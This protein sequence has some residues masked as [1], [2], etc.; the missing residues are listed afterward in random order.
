MI[1]I[2][3]IYSHQ[4]PLGTGEYGFQLKL[5][6]PMFIYRKKFNYCVCRNFSLY[7][8]Q[9]INLYYHFVKIDSLPSPRLFLPKYFSSYAPLLCNI[10]TQSKE[11]SSQQSSHTVD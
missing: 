2:C 11:N 6:T 5:Y 8:K 3:V 1:V 10:H 9:Y 4:R 7:Q